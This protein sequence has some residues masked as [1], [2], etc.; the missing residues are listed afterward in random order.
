MAS[1]EQ[2]VLGRTIRRNTIVL[3][4]SL[5]LSW[6]VVQLLVSVAAPILADLTGRRS[7]AGVG[8]A[9]ALGFWAVGTLVVGRYMDARGRAPG[10]RLGFAV[11]AVGYVVLFIGT[12]NRS[13]PLYL[14]GLAVA[15]AGGGAINLARAGGGDMYPPERRARGISFV[16]VGAAFGAILG[17]L[18]FTPFLVQSGA[19]L[20][21]LAPPFMAG[22]LIML[23]G[24]ALT[25]VIRVDPIEIGRML[26]E[27]TAS[28]IEAPARHLK[29][30]LQIPLVRVAVTAAVVSQGVMAMMMSTVSLHLR[31]HGHGWTAI[32][33]V[34]SAHFL[35][36]FGLVL[37]VGRLVDRI[38]RERGLV[39]GL[40]ILIVGVVALLADVQLQWVTPAMLIVGVGWNVSFVAATAMLADATSPIERAGLLGFTDF[41]GMGSSAFASLVAG[42]V[43]GAVG[44]GALVALGTAVALVPVVIFVAGGRRVRQLA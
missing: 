7:I 16:L 21:V 32:S 30:L 41:L 25:W 12:R 15:G 13:L 6:A 34:L 29:E 9:I 33:L 20:D 40:L 4:A 10:V 11:A 23:L 35:G 43:I 2:L 27:G 19:D 1:V 36:M 31:E 28:E 22:A 26:R 24:A 39:F 17:P 42:V 18:V 8:P 38:G 5:A 3:A 14:L 44:I 37:F